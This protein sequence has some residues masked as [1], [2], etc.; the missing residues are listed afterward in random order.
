MYVNHLLNMCANTNTDNSEGFY[1]RFG[2]R[3]TDLKN[4]NDQSTLE[5]VND[6]IFKWFGGSLP[7][8]YHIEYYS[9]VAKKVLHLT[10][11]IFKSK[12][13]PF[14]FNPTINS[15]KD[16][17]VTDWV[18]MFIVDDTPAETE[19]NLQPSKHIFLNKFEE[20]C[21]FQTFHSILYQLMILHLSHF[22]K[23]H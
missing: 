23:T 18:E 1:V 6:H 7:S 11:D 17:R 12:N 15:Q 3:S 10:E 4:F 22:R 21:F 13:N 2:G 8:K 9:V 5:D 19:I 14:L 20:K 16:Q